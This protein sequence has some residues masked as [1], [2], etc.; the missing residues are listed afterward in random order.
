MIDIVSTET[1]LDMGIFDTDVERAKN[2][3]SVQLEA[4]TYLQ[5]FGIDL[6]YFL[7][8][9]FAFENESFKSYLI[10][11][12]ANYGINVTKVLETMVD[13][14]VLNLDFNI[15]SNSNDTAMVAR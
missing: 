15:G 6:R 14:L 2:I 1:G 7:N 5:D 9:D 11:R 3:L 8:E 13:G 10:Q 12:L 4:L